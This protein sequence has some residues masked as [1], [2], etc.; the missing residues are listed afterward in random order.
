MQWFQVDKEGLA[1]LLERRGKSY[2]IFELIQNALDEQT[3]LVDVMLNR[4]PGTRRVRLVVE[5]DNPAGFF[6]LSHAFTIF[7]ESSKKDSAEKRGRF[8]LGEKLCLAL[9]DE[10]EIASTKGTVIFSKEGRVISRKKRE[11]G[12]RIECILK[13]T[14]AEI[15]ECER[16]AMQILPPAGITVRFNGKAVPARTALAEFEATLATEIADAEGVLR[17]TQRKTL[18]RIIEPIDGEAPMLYELGIPVVTAGDI[19]WHIDVQQKLPLNMDRDGVTP[20]YLSRINALVLQHMEARLS[21]QDANATWVKDA[22]QRHGE[23]L[24]AAVVQRV[25]DLRFGEKRVVFDPSDPESNHR[26]VAA[27]Y[28]VIH[29]GQLSAEEWNAVRRTGAALPAG[30]VTPSP[31]PF[32]DDPDAKPLKLLPPERW[33]DAI[34]A[35][36][37]YAERIGQRLLGCPVVVDVASDVTWP[38]SGAYGPGRLV[39]NHGRLGNGWFERKDLAEINQLL[40]HEFG[41]HYSLNHLGTE[42]HEALC[43]LGGKMTRLALTEPSLCEIDARSD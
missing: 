23:D 29:G 39:L 30:R 11:C 32:S 2:I 4:I 19:P 3:T 38:F 16:A 43:K 26:A 6:N 41:H 27:G 7:A 24:P 25:I 10:A 9:C 37:S 42:F 34:R 14:D 31:K 40:I 8:N 18:V 21:T 13:M 28:T 5:D 36:V 35:V 17:R 12:S 22:I 15:G 1:K 33:T 20:A